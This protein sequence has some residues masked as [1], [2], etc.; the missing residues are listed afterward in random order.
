MKA[1]VCTA[2]GPPN[3]LQ[4][5]ERETP[6]PKDNE[7]LVRVHATSVN[8]MDWRLFTMPLLMRRLIGRG[9]DKPKNGSCGADLAGIVEAV[10]PAVT[11]F[12]AGD[13]VFG[14]QIGAFAEYVCAP[15]DRLVSKPAHVSFE[16]TAAVPVAALTAL[17]GVR[18]GK[19]TPGHKVLVNGSGG[20]VGTFSVQIAKAFG[21]E[22]TAVCSTRNQDVARSIGADHVLDYTRE[23]PTR[24]GHRYDAIIAVNGY[25]SMLDYRRALNPNGICVVLGGA[26]GQ[27]LQGALFAPVLN[28]IG[29]K[30]TRGVMGHPKHD[31]LI[32]LQQLLETGKIVPVIDRTYSLADVAAAV[33]YLIAG[34][35]SGKV[36]ITVR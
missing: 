11:K 36:V 27:L 26:A 16:A 28:L 29:N 31:E 7:V 6:T 34:H 5:L 10:G 19:V 12:R 35:S 21:A 9:W 4:L 8:A 14:I 13:A 3:V 1:I 33:S 2:Y 32:A 22:V 20:G 30:K 25:H 23:D 15:E 18:E 17:R 24:A